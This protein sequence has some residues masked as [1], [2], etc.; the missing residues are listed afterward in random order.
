VIAWATEPPRPRPSTRGTRVASAVR[1]SV[2]SNT[3][4]VHSIVAWPRSEVTTRPY[5]PAPHQW[6]RC[7]TSSYRAGHDSAQTGRGR[8]QGARKGRAARTRQ[9]TPGQRPKRQGR[10]R[11]RRSCRRPDPKPDGTCYAFPRKQ[12]KP[13]T[14]SR[15]VARSVTGGWGDLYVEAP[16]RPRGAAAGLR[17][18]GRGRGWVRSVVARAPGPAPGP[19][20]GRRVRPSFATSNERSNGWRLRPAT[21]DPSDLHLQ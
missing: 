19:G 15:V 2:A 6:V 8:P 7:V 4:P 10:R 18:R 5:G 14:A 1:M 21:T 9:A 17:L 13:G 12:R 3:R 16:L 11:H 20:Q